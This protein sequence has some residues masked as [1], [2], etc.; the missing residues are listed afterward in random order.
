[1]SFAKTTPALSARPN[2]CFN[3]LSPIRCIFLTSFTIQNFNMGSFRKAALGLAVGMAAVATAS[4][5]HDLKADDFAPFVK[6]NNLVLAEFFA[7]WLAGEQQ[8]VIV[9]L[10]TCPKVRSLQSISARVRGSCNNP[11]GEEH[12]LGQG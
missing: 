1:M 12:R 11:Q 10:L 5:V 3:A 4:D 8:Y 6:E 7:P 2:L 9:S